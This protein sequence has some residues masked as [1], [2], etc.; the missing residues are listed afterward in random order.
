[1]AEATEGTP[2]ILEL[3]DRAPS[4]RTLLE[5]E[6]AR[7]DSQEIHWVRS[8]PELVA[9]LPEG[10][11]QRLLAVP[12]YRDAETGRVDVAA[13]DTLGPHIATEFAYQ[14][15]S[16]V[17]VLRAELDQIRLALASITA[18]QAAKLEQPA[19]I[20]TIPPSPHQVKPPPLPSAP[21]IP[22][23]RRT[24]MSSRALAPLPD[25]SS[26][27]AASKPTL[28]EPLFAF[29]LELDQALI[30]L[31]RADS[32]ELVARWISRALEPAIS[33]VLALRAGNLEPRASSR[34]LGARLPRALPHDKN[35]IFEQALRA[36]FYLGKVPPNFAHAELRALLPAS[37]QEEVYCAPVI[38]SG[39]PV[40]VLL[41][42]EFGPS[43]AATRRADRLTAAAASA[44]ER[45]L[46]ARKRG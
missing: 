37:A 23:V 44:I 14:L 33:L 6:L 7:A 27:P 45:I 5:R 21:P 26:L 10:F 31:G 34:A 42:A 15:A 9:E 29:E 8:L 20:S 36:G 32:A 12:V 4:L 25:G 24:P 30:E 41:L 3:I 1:M 43:L 39:R 40:L 18:N 16:P 17:R 2:F 46:L 11:C 35:S 22:L 19:R 28:P 13:V 38:V